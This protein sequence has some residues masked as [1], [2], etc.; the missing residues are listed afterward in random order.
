M[1]QTWPTTLWASTPHRNKKFFS[2]ARIHFDIFILF[3][4][5]TAF[6]NVFF[7]IKTFNQ[8]YFD[9]SSQ[10]LRLH[11]LN[12]V[13]FETIPNSF[14]ANFEPISS[15]F[16]IKLKYILKQL[17]VIFCLNYKL[18]LNYFQAISTSTS[19]QPWAKSE[20]LSS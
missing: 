6:I 5:P 17:S 1:F 12:Q 14:R 10:Q 8:I 2:P 16:R 18:I 13:H 9:P 11:A 7:S 20:L 19:S 4:H 15:Q 3:S